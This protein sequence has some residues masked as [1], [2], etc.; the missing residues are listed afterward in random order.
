[1][2]GSFLWYFKVLDLSMILCVS[3][4]QTGRPWTTPYRTRCADS[5]GHT[6]VSDPVY[7]EIINKTR[8]LTAVCFMSETDS[9]RVNR[10]W[11]ET[12]QQETVPY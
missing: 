7:S 12:L 1:M 11:R 3:V 6:H 5:S 9:D 4:Q 2:Y 10:G 8:D